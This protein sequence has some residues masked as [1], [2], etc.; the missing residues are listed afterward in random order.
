VQLAARFLET[1]D[2]PTQINAIAIEKYLLMLQK[3]G[4]A[5]KTIK[6]HLTAIKVFCDYLVM[7]EILE[8]N[9]AGKIPTLQS[10]EEVPVCLSESEIHTLY[11][12]AR[13][14]DMMC[15]VTLALKTGMRMEEMRRLEW[16]D[17]DLQRRQ[18]LVRKSKGKRPR[19]IP[20]HQQAIEQLKIQQIRYGH[21]I[22][23]FP[24]G[25]GGP[26]MKHVWDVPQMRGVNW[27]GRKSIKI[28]QKEIPTLK[29]LPT[30]STGRG[31]HALRHTFATRAIKADVDVVKLRDWMG[32]KK[33]E[34]TLRYIH[35]A[36]HYDPDIERV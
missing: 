35:V 10:P 32:H 34:T 23:V 14:F 22:Y 31:W 36:R 17:V 27:W 11:G 24:A 26:N 30:R 13:K 16:I 21:L 12:V 8:D 4:R 15:E 5:I 6:N 28:L 9:P 3:K 7:H 29:K 2:E 20:L 19:T 25:R 1:V 33:I 18:L